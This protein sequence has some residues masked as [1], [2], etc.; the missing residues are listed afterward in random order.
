MSALPQISVVLPVYNQA[1]HIAPVIEAHLAALAR[2]GH[3]HEMVLVPNACRDATAEVCRELGAG[4]P[5]IKVV[6][7][8]RGGWGRAVRA[9]LEAADGELLCYT[10]SARTTPEMLTL[11][12]AYA[13]AYPDVVLKANRKIRDSWRRRLGSVLYNLECRSLFHLPTWDVNGTPK[14]FPRGFGAL[15]E[16]ERNDDL[17]DVELL[18]RCQEHGYPVLEV[19]IAQ[20]VRHGGRSTT[21]YGSAVR[22]YLGAYLMRDG[23]TAVEPAAAPASTAP[24]DGA[25]AAALV[26]PRTA[27]AGP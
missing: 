12:L 23:S 26:A 4:D 25:L 3:S 6:E 11:M 5:R 9:G 8:K 24:A 20:T 15:L 13:I 16:L 1:D 18:W 27:E 19:P 21:G 17:I 7:L 14:V 10:N 22:M 2:L